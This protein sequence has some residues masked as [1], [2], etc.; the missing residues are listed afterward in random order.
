[1]KILGIDLS[2]PA[3]LAD[4][5]LAAF[6]AHGGELHFLQ[7]LSAA[8]D[9]RILEIA[10][11]LHDDE[12]VVGLDAPLSYQ[13]GG[14]YRPS[15]RALRDRLRE[16]GCKAGVMAPTLTR[17]AYLT[18]RGISVARTLESA[19]LKARTRI[20]EVHPGAGLCL[21]GASAE[22][23]A[24][25]KQPGRSDARRR[26]LGWLAGHGLAGIPAE[27]PDTDHLVDACAAALAAWAWGRGEPVWNFPAQPPFHPYD[28]AC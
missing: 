3:N 19:P 18:L 12:L 25:Y 17:M 22:D 1:M 13:S 20:V 4:T 10:S 7:A 21:R 14:G 26:V 23:L 8:D 5:C 28:F 6:E 11:S 2:G 24:V 15:D 27:T 16:H 9:A